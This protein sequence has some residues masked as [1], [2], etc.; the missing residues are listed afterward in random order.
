MLAEKQVERMSGLLQN[1][2][3]CELANSTPSR[4]PAPAYGVPAQQQV[5]PRRVQPTESRVVSDLPLAV[6]VSDKA[7]LRSGPG[8][9]NSPIASVS[10]GTRL[11]IQSRQGEW[12]LVGAPN[13]GSAWV[14]AEVLQFV[15][16][17][18]DAGNL[19]NIKIRPVDPNM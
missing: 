8:K 6:V 17:G 12:Y 11:A 10:R 4:V 14:N 2:N 16:S 19:P 7:L 9:D 15:P 5:A 3:A 18:A 13:G 1:R